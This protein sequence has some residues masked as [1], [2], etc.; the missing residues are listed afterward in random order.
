MQF[1][2]RQNIKQ[3]ILKQFHYNNILRLGDITE[4]KSRKNN[5]N[6]LKNAKTAI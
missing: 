5:L 2:K 6:T 4:R 3:K 1:I